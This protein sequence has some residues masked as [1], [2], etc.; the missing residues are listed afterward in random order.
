MKK[1]QLES[2][3][4]S[5]SAVFVNYIDGLAIVGS[6][7]STRLP[8]DADQIYVYSTHAKI[9]VIIYRN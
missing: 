2:T 8:Y 4:P 7:Y 6:I 5:L 9:F 3:S 1:C